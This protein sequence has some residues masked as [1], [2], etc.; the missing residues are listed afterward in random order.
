[1]CFQCQRVSG[2]D[3]EI[4]AGPIIVVLVFIINA[5]KNPPKVFQSH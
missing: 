1:M 5:S 2:V 4:H 3:M